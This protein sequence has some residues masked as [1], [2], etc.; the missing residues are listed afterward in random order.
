MRNQ[1]GPATVRGSPPVTRPLEQSG[2][3]QENDEPEP[4]NLPVFMDFVPTVDGRQ[5]FFIPE[6]KSPAR[7]ADRAFFF[8]GG[9]L[10]R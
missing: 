6:A 5:S 10:W 4:G 8:A 9:T 3:A 7:V 2:K 1:R